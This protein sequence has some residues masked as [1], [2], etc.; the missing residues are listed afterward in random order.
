M[1]GRRQKGEGSLY[2]RGAKGGR[3]GQWVA[4]AD[5]GWREGSRDR[6]E[7]TGP[8]AADAIARRNA[9]LRKREDG[10]TMPKGRQPYVSE[11]L[12][13]WLFNIAQ[14]KVEVTTWERSYRQKTLDLIC[15]YFERVPLP[16]LDEEMIEQWHR[17]LG[18]KVSGRTGRPLSASTIAQAH[19]IFSVA[20]NVAV[21][22]K[23][24]GRNPCSLVTPPRDEDEAEP[25]TLTEDD[26][27]AI[28]REC[29]DRRTG[30]RWL[31]AI[32]CGLRQG[33]GLGL[34][35]PFVDI[36]D[37]EN[38][39]IEVDW[40]LVRLTWRHGCDDPRG[41]SEHVVPCP[42]PC[43]KVRPS[44]RKHHCI[45][46]GDKRLC[47]PGCDRHASR[48]PKRKGG[49][50]LKRPKSAKSRR[51][52]PLPPL[53]AAALR[54]WATDQTAERLAC[55][56][57][58]GWAHDPAECKRKLKAGQHV[59][60]GCRKPAKP[61]TLVFANPDGT[62]TDPNADWRDW[63]GMLEDSGVEHLG[64]HGGRHSFATLLLEGGTDIRVVQE[65]MGH[66]TPGFTQR[67]YQHV[68]PKP[69][70]DAASVIDKALRG[71]L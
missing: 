62:P 65:L 20:L 35:W 64:T 25:G 11:W 14:A 69:K 51:A 63:A 32:G 68:R 45:P 21:V 24:I 47:P 67:S 30:A 26:L 59:C 1:P 57:W 29:E 66:S 48:C 37:S 2:Q 42:R 5:L 17:D 36:E 71:G 43:P 16:D 40:E 18:R 52:I 54:Q 8:T 58:K 9:F 19:R 28:V 27:L 70:R 31:T 6:R 38:A 34:L 50:Q 4:V 39:S 53:A 13:H 3:P 41:C 33:E 61:G 44:G 22:R 60:P 49:L 56:G 23:R 10:F 46:A 7:F 55:P 12:A 15:P